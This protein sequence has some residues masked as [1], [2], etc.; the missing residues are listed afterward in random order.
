MKLKMKYCLLATVCAICLL[1]GT[2]FAA[3]TDSTKYWDTHS[4]SLGLYWTFIGHPRITPTFIYFK[5]PF[6]AKQFGVYY[7]RKI[8][9]NFGGGL[10]YSEWNVFKKIFRSMPDGVYTIG[11]PPYYQPGSVQYYKFYKM[12]DAYLYY[13]RRFRERHD[14]NVGI[15]VSYTWGINTIVDSVTFNP[16]PP[17]D[18]IV[19]TSDTKSAY[20]GLIF[21]FNYD[22]NLLNGHLS[23]GFDG[24]YRRYKSL[25][26]PRV[27]YGL[28]IRVN[29]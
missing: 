1:F 18:G 5:F 21:V 12:A 9:R 19:Y 27:D 24:K 16:N 7:E 15:G 3:K 28:H 4:N 26:S 17:F 2:V 13:K 25:Y 6:N 20:N 23:V 11:P 8:H 14:V 10:G 29:F 22:Y